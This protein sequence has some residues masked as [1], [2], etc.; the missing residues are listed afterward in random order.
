MLY[1]LREGI[2]EFVDVD[3]GVTAFPSI[4]GCEIRPIVLRK[5]MPVLFLECAKLCGAFRVRLDAS[6][7]PFPYRIVDFYF[8]A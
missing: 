2:D 6:R 1:V 5:R 3:L 7:E 8:R 4:Q